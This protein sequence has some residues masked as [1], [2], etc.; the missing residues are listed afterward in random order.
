MEPRE[1][2][3]LAQ[4][5]QIRS[6]DLG[7]GHNLVLPRLLSYNSLCLHSVPYMPILYILSYPV[8]KNQEFCEISE[9]QSLTQLNLVTFLLSGQEREVYL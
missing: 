9:K 4:V 5:G 7:L 1:G 2:K 3:N 8:N 6:Q